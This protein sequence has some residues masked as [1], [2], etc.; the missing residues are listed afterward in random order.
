[1][2]NGGEGG[3]GQ[4]VRVGGVGDRRRWRCKPIG[5][6]GASVQKLCA[7][8]QQGVQVPGTFVGGGLRGSQFFFFLDNERGSQISRLPPGHN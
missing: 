1:M 5:D 3:D 7:G 4:R 8:G 2:A 6:G